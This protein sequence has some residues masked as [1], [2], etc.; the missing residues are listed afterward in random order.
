MKDEDIDE[1]KEHQRV[2]MYDYAFFRLDREECCIVELTATNPIGGMKT[3]PA[4]RESN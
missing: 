3:K 2:F 1:E 4:L